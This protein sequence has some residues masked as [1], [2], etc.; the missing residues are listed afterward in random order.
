MTIQGFKFTGNQVGVHV[1]STTVLDRLLVQ[2]SDFAG[3]T[4]H[5]VGTG[6]GAPTVDRIDILNSTFEQNGNGSQNGDGDIVLFGFTGASLIQNVTIAGGAN[7]VPT[8]ANADTAI[9]INGRDPLSYDVTHP[10]GNVVFDNVH[11]TGSYAK[12]LVYIQGYIDLDGLSFAGNGNNFSGHAGWG[13]A[14]AIDPTADETSSATPGVPGEP[15]FFDAAAA[16]ALGPDT[17]DLSHVTVSNDIPINVTAG[18]P[19]FALNGQALGTVFSGTPAVDNVTGTDGVDLFLTRGGNDVIHAGGGNDAILYT[20]GDGVDTIDGGTGTDTLFVSGTAGNDTIHAVVNGSGV[21]SSIEGMS[22]TGVELFKVDAGS[23]TDTLDYS[24]TTSAV[25]VNLAAGTATGFASAAGFENV[26]GGTGNDSLTGNA[27]ANTLT[28]GAGDDTLNGGMGADTMVGGIG[29]DTYVVDN[30]GDVV[31]EALNAGTDTVQ[32]SISYTLGAN[33]E[34]LTLTD[35]A[36]NTQTFDD[37]ALGPIADGENGWKVAGPARDQAVVNVAGSNNAFHISSD[38]VSGDFGGPYSPAL[39]AA[40][41]ESTVSAYQ[42]QSIGFDLKAVSPTV[43]G[44]RLEVDFAN[45]A[46]TDRN[47]FLVIESTGSGLRIA[48][49]EPT[50]AGDWAVNNFSAFTGNRTLVSGIDQSVSHHLEMRLT[51]VDGQNN[52]RIDIY[53]DGA[54]IGTTTT[55]ENYR[56]FS[57]DLAP[58]P[59]HATNIAANL[60]DRVLFRT[61]DAGQ[62]HDG[63][64]G[65]NQG[66]NI[67]N[68]TT[69]VYNNSSATG[70]DGA[71]VITGNSGDNVITGL[72][73]ADTLHGGGGNDTLIGGLGNDTITG[74]AGDDVVQYT[75]G[76]GVDIIDGGAGTDTLAVSGTAGNDTIHVSLNGSGVI[77]SVEGMSPTN[78]ERYTVDGGSGSDTLTYTGT[79]SAVT[80]NLAT[81]SATG[82]TSVTGVENVT[83]GSGND[84]LTGDANANVLTGGAGADTLIGG[85]GNDTFRHVAGDGAD[86]IDGGAGSNT[87]DYT[88]SVSAVT[89]DLSTGAATDIASL[90]HIQNVIGGSAADT[91]TGDAG[92]NKLTGG[93]GN[94][95]IFGGDGLD[96]AV[97]AS[98]FAVTAVVANS[99]GG[100]TVTTGN[101]DGTDTLSGIEYIEHSGGRYVL[102]DPT[103]THSGFASVDAAIAAGTRPGDTLVFAAEPTDPINIVTNDT[104]DIII[105]YNVDTDVQTG[106]GD[107]HVQTAGGDD[108]VITG[109]G[110]DTVKTGGGDDVVETGGGDDT[111]IGGSG[112]GDD[113]YDGGLGSDTVLYPSAAHSITVDLNLADRH[114]EPASGGGTIGALL[115]AAGYADNTPVGKAEGVDIGTDA[116][117]GIENVVGGSANDT[118]TGNS[119]DNIITGGL[120]DDILNGGGGDDTFKYTIGDGLDIVNG[121][122]NTAIGD[123]LAVSGTTGDDT[124]HVVLNG[125]DV[126]TTIEGMTPTGVENYTLD[127]LANGAAGDT[128]DYTGTTTSV[129]VNLATPS[130]TGF[131]SI[132][133]IENVIGGSGVDSLTG[134]NGN[135]RLDGGGGVDTMAGG[136]GDDTYVVDSLGETVTELSNAGADTVL[137]SLA[138]YTLGVNV[139]NLTL[140]G[141]GN[142]N[143]TGNGDANTLTGNSG[144]NTLDGDVGADT[145]IGGLGNDIYVVDDAGD[146]VTELLNGGTDT[147]RSTVNY[148]LTANVENLIL[149]AAAG[150]IAGTGNALANTITG[151]EGDNVLTGAAGDDTLVG[152]TGNDTLNGQSGHDTLTGGAGA[153]K[154]K[155]DASSLIP[156]QPGATVLDH[157]L[158]YNQG[159]TGTYSLAEDDTL[160][161]SALLATAFGNGQLVGN[162]VRVSENSTGTAA[163]LQIDQDGTAN[164]SIFTTIAQIDGIHAGDSLKVILDSSLPPATATLT[165]PVPLRGVSFDGDSKSDILWQSNNG[166]VAAWLMDGTTA[167]TVTAAGS[168]NPGP[169]WHVKGSGDFDGDGKADIIWQGDNGTAAMWLMDGPNT[170]F[171]GAVGPFNPGPTWH[172]EGTGD[173]NGDGKSDIIWQGD[174]GTAAMWLMDGTNTT[175][176]GAVG[177]FN[178]GPAWH[179]KGT[180]DFNGDG[181]S[182]IIWQGDNGTAAMW[183]MDG[184]TATFVGAVGSNP[185]PNWEIKGT[186]DFNG[187]GKSDLV[188]QGKDGTAAVWLMDGTNVVSATAVGSNPGPTWEIKGTGDFNGDGKSDILWQGQNGTPAIWLM[189]GTDVVSVH[190]AGSF[191]PGSDWH[192]II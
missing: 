57:T 163:F 53:L 186:G 48:V 35:A 138:N 151:N 115:I 15:G 97:F 4:I 66:F 87:L 83:G 32:S 102:I 3:N 135:N 51:Y 149:V 79:T 190:A 24:G 17:V 164:G 93:G 157:I 152:G 117:I 185:G 116:L 180:G 103:L 188:W 114:L 128:L 133:G 55:F 6:S 38:I 100:W 61:G 119:G 150:S 174:N 139:E 40:A 80:V 10:I 143:G 28:G 76:D 181:K 91:L 18:H 37:M 34:N 140:T 41:G 169:T 184:T 118:I 187:D 71:N 45:A 173:F 69:A 86:V 110:D 134:D 155:F 56:D 31:T 47:N 25:T 148:A 142:I 154:F 5:G 131:A 167:T 12:V 191:N 166:T 14:L 9:Q 59:A 30:V 182:D 112:N 1:S 75:L 29:N 162:L 84:S 109:T 70:N 107:N 23:G 126:I 64:G 90:A 156:E 124:I 141:S 104:V 89:V 72:G 125:S 22:P 78:V 111:I 122:T 85:D 2:N 42:G 13:W 60:T 144:N 176:V 108:T 147:V 95:A 74:D 159:N 171:V 127:G 19:L 101:G 130:A 177:P 175:F 36:S 68:V 170:T 73:G 183:L 98:T 20:I 49:N 158:D 16:N 136:L 132:A 50:T 8:N 7:A 121:G 88:G 52:D 82:L 137:S 120:G 160:D 46:G 189:D 94:D 165:A 172:I 54:L 77:G 65:L 123:T 11:V 27:S 62:P 39:S 161:L 67:D 146:V 33:V 129:T 145:M 178:P 44:S 21:I 63:P 26:T 153:D 99:S 43:D 106:D 192:V 96:T 81:G 168:F 113:V 105:P 92:A 179:I 58:N